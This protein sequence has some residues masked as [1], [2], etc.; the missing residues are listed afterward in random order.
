MEIESNLRSFERSELERKIAF[1]DK[2]INLQN[3]IY[4]NNL[5]F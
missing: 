1:P 4:E 5:L 3:Y 2:L